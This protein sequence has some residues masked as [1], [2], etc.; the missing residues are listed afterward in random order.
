MH[1][2]Y[3]YG[4]EEHRLKYLP[5]LAKGN[6]VG[7]FGLTEPNHGSNPGDMESRARRDGDHFILN[8]SKTW[9]GAIGFSS[10]GCL[11]WRA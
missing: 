2:I 4:S 7:A 6:L 11:T 5:E 8:G 10:H 3:T 1:P 9:Y